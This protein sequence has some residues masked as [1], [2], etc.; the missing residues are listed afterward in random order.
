MTYMSKN[1]RNYCNYCSVYWHLNG[2]LLMSHFRAQT[3]MHSINTIELNRT[4]IRRVHYRVAAF[5]TEQ[6]SRLP[7]EFWHRNT[8]NKTKVLHANCTFNCNSTWSRHS[9][10]LNSTGKTNPPQTRQI[11]RLYPEL[12]AFSLTLNLL[13][14]L[15]FQIFQ[16]T[17]GNL[18]LTVNEWVHILATAK[19]R[20]TSCM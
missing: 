19:H 9:S 17:Y 15:G 8:G 11:P 13:T 16:Q 4:Q 6:I 14:H 2:K 3:Q 18:T 1:Y 20:K 7:G 10:H 12:L 5:Q